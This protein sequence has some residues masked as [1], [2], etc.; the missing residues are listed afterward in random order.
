MVW[1]PK[2][3]QV[4]FNDPCGRVRVNS[5]KAFDWSCLEDPLRTS[6]VAEGG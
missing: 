5:N 3:K 6:A 2:G 4:L 1:Q